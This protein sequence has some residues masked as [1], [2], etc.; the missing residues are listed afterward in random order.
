MFKWWA[1]LHKSSFTDIHVLVY[2][3]YYCITFVISRLQ[4][5][6]FTAEGKKQLQ[7]AAEERKSYP[8][9]VELHLYL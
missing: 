7:Q 2:L 6:K 9:F 1:Q 4:V 5:N 8:D 3:Q